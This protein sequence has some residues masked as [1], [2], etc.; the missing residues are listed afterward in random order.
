MKKSYENWINPETKKKEKIEVWE[1]FFEDWENGIISGWEN[2]GKKLIHNVSEKKRRYDILSKDEFMKI[3]KK[4]KEIYWQKVN[5]AFGRMKQRF[6]VRLSKSRDKERLV[7]I[8]IEKYEYLFFPEKRKNKPCPPQFN[9]TLFLG[10]D[11]LYNKLIVEG[12]QDYSIINN[13]RITIG[14]GDLHHIKVET[15]AKFLEWLKT[16]TPQQKGKKV[17]PLKLTAPVI[18]CF[19]SLVNESELIPKDESSNEIYC[20]K[21]CEKFNLIYTDRIRQNFSNRHSDKTIKKVKEH[22]LTKIDDKKSKKINDFISNKLL[23]KQKLYV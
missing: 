1:Y 18:A 12:E 11:N 7:N 8:E 15:Y 14:A 5:D 23:P 3:D 19:C 2:A 4:C 21:V 22:I 16:L 9:S 10:Y 17:S 13:S 6:N 20:K